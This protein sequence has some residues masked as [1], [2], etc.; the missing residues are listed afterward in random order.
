MKNYVLHGF[1]ALGLAACAEPSEAPTSL[2]TEGAA[3]DPERW[4]ERIDGLES[5][6][7]DSRM[8]QVFEIFHE[9]RDPDTADLGLQFMQEYPGHERYEEVLLMTCDSLFYRR[10]VERAIELLEQARDSS[11]QASDNLQMSL[12]QAYA[13]AFQTDRAVQVYE[14]L[15]S[16][17][18]DQ[19]TQALARFMATY[20]KLYG[21][22]EREAMRELELMSLE[23]RSC[24]DPDLVPFALA[25]ETQLDIAR[26]WNLPNGRQP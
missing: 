11:G 7:R 26:G 10:E 23:F 17:S 2:E 5:G 24:E 1:I 14:K 16:S 15:G 4:F 8:L 25:A 12:A 21:G 18:K 20:S 3:L 19:R 13:Q 6:P 22:K 9:H